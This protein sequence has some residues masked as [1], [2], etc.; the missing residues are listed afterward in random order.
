[1]SLREGN[2]YIC[3]Y[4]LWHHK[5]VKNGEPSSNN[6]WIYT[7]IARHLG[8]VD[9]EDYYSL[10]SVYQDCKGK[11]DFTLERFPDYAGVPPISRDEIIGMRSLEFLPI[12]LLTENKWSFLSERKKYEV[13]FIRIAKALWYLK[14]KHRNE[15]WQKPV[16]DAWSVGF[17][18]WHHDRHHLL[19]SSFRLTTVFNFIMFNLYALITLLR[20][21]SAEKN[22][23]WVQLMDLK[24]SFWIRFINVE[25]DLLD[26]FGPDHPFYQMAKYKICYYGSSKE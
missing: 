2:V 15:I 11:G 9:K 4:G 19:I 5:P 26:V 10:L 23:L 17:K 14:D 25:K 13:G 24:S 7:A 21:D 12:E 6:G 16:K 22:L 20:N 18:I 1:M 8:L 3:K